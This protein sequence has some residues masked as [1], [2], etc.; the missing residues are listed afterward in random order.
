M[1]S[2]RDQNYGLSNW[3][4][5]TV[6]GRSMKEID[7]HKQRA[8]AEA[9]ALN[10]IAADL[11]VIARELNDHGFVFAPVDLRELAGIIRSHSDD[12][13]KNTTA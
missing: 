1:M 5:P 2:I 7:E 9:D 6:K 3:Q 12:I 13:R 8:D 4:P 10:V 11:D